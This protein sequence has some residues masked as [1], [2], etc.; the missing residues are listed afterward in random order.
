MV[1]SSDVTDKEWAIIEPKTA[2][3]E[4]N[5][6]ANLDKTRNPERDI[7]STQEWLQLVGFT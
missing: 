2:N 1:Y 6:T 5:K 4:E 7:L 3:Q